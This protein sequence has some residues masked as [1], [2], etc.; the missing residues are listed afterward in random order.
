MEKSLRNPLVL[1]LT[2]ALP[3]SRKICWILMPAGVPSKDCMFSNSWI[4]RSRLEA[5][6]QRLL[7]QRNVWLQLKS[8]KKWRARF[9]SH[10]KTTLVPGQNCAKSSVKSIRL[11][12][13][14]G[15]AE[16]ILTI[17]FCWRHKVYWGGSQKISQRLLES[18]AKRSE[19]PSL[20]SETCSESMTKTLRWLTRSW[21]ITQ[22]LFNRWWSTK[23]VG[24]KVRHISAIPKK[25]GIYCISQAR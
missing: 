14:V 10:V 11:P 22:T 17:V 16:T 9:S 2:P 21:K 20:I 8:G 23:K 12:T 19:V 5:S 25:E 15:E 18:W 4:L 13:T 7:M 3:K 24:K 1:Q 6:L